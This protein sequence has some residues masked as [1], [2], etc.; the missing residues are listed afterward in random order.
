MI[1]RAII[2]DTE[3][4]VDLTFKLFLESQFSKW[5]SF[6]HDDVRSRI[7]GYIKPEN[8]NFEIFVSEVNGLVV[9]YISCFL[10][11]LDFNTRHII[12]SEDKW[13]VDK[14]YRS[15]LSGIRLL[16]AFLMWSKQKKVSSIVIDD[17]ALIDHDGIGRI[18]KKKEFN[19]DGYSYRRVL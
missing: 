18:L 10:T 11:S 7:I 1:R 13:F 4:L 19:V 8:N 12:A 6:S 3:Y 9:G 16:D 17:R 5:T 2:E 15:G 14:E